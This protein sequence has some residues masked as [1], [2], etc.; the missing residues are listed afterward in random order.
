MKCAAALTS[1]AVMA[2]IGGAT[3]VPAIASPW[4]L[5]VSPT[6]VKRGGTVMIRVT[7]HAQCVIAVK[8]PRLKVVEG[9]F[10]RT[11][12][13]TVPKTAGVGTA[14]VE[15]R[16][17]T[18]VNNAKFK[19][20]GRDGGRAPGP[21]P[22]PAPDPAPG[23]APAP[24]PIQT[25]TPAP[26]PTPTAAPTPTPTPTATPPSTSTGPQLPANPWTVSSEP[27]ADSPNGITMGNQSCAPNQITISSP[28]ITTPTGTYVYAR[29][30]V[31][32]KPESQ[33]GDLTLTRWGDAYYQGTAKPP[34]FDWS[35]LATGGVGGQ[36]TLDAWT[37]K[38]GYDAEIIQWVWDN[39]TWYYNNYS[40]CAF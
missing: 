39:G 31:Y 32:T 29:D 20:E 28:L 6:T 11:A 18:K 21:K 1:L 25:P 19:I 24:A 27:V 30:A 13:L 10:H 33:A 8:M 2:L 34:I 5:R 22:V 7:S 15:V 17:G 4:S 3:A 23:P 9:K 26:A 37:I 14:I 36:Q 12:R 40:D 16:C 35:D 38:S